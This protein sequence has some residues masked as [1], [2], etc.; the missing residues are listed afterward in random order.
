MEG[1]NFDVGLNTGGFSSG[2]G[3][4]MNSLN[5]LAGTAKTVGGIIATALGGQWNWRRGY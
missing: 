2:I 3:G 4:M 1:I 5:S